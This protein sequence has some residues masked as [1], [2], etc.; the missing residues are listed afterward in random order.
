M[1]ERQQIPCLIWGGAVQ[2]L[3]ALHWDEFVART[4]RL[5]PAAL[6]DAG[7]R[8]ADL[9]D[10]IH[11]RSAPATFVHGDLRADNVFFDPRGDKVTLIDW[12]DGRVAPALHDVAYFLATSLA[13]PNRRDIER[14]VGGYV[15][16][17]K[18]H[19]VGGYEA[20]DAICDLR[21]CA[22]GVFVQNALSVARADVATAHGDRLMAVMAERTVLFAEATDLVASLASELAHV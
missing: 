20:E 22:I 4:G 10:F 6:R 1:T 12:E 8:L 19:G 11:P 9:A 17:L 3:F 5:L 18:W 13:R 2:R 14:V 21:A 16:Q 15:E 7:R